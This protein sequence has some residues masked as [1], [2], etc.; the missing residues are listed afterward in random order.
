[1]V[2]RLDELVAQ[3]LERSQLTQVATK[4]MIAQIMAH[5]SVLE[6]T[7]RAWEEQVNTSGELAQGL[8]AFAAR[9]APIFPWRRSI[10]ASTLKS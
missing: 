9:R 3:L 8:E 1:M 7:Q 2:T 5:G 6:S 4:Q 10:S